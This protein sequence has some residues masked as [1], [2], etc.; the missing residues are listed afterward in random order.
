MLKN[1][2]AIPDENAPEPSVTDVAVTDDA[3][4]E[5]R[6]RIT[7]LRAALAQA[8]SAAEDARTAQQ[9]VCGFFDGH[10][11][12]FWFSAHFIE[13]EDDI[14]LATGVLDRAVRTVD[15]ILSDHLATIIEDSI[16]ADPT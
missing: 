9:H 7:G 2:P 5:L 3:V 16:D 15:T 10:A 4:A 8:K 6:Q 11:P 14:E 1:A 12:L 13:M